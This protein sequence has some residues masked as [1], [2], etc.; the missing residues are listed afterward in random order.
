MGLHLEDRVLYLGA[1]ETQGRSQVLIERSPMIL[2]LVLWMLGCAGVLTL[3]QTLFAFSF[4]EEP[5]EVPPGI[6]FPD[7][8]IDPIPLLWSG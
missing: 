5:P 3:A 1:M 7:L 2:I 4:R 6:A 8:A